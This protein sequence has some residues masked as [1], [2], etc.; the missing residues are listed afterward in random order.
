MAVARREFRVD[1]T[2][3]IAGIQNL[4]VGLLQ[5]ISIVFINFKARPAFRHAVF[6]FSYLAFDRLGFYELVAAAEDRTKRQHKL[7]EFR[8]FVFLNL[9][10]R[11]PRNQ[12]MI[13][14]G[15]Q[16]LLGK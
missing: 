9:R 11:K 14:D 5:G 13:L 16:V 4:E 6:E 10:A 15:M 12:L 8:H 3:V 2:T 7:I 1:T